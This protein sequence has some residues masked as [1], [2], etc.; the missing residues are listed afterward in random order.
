MLTQH[1]I[2]VGLME[3]SRHDRGS[4]ALMAIETDSVVL[5]EVLEEIGNIPYIFDVSLLSLQ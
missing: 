4:R 2:N 1:K 3:V 5:P